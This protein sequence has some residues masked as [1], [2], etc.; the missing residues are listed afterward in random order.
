LDSQFQSSSSSSAGVSL[1]F[2]NFKP[3]SL[4]FS[5]LATSSN[6]GALGL[7][8]PDASKV[9][10]WGLL[11]P[12]ASKF[13]GRGLLESYLRIAVLWRKDLREQLLKLKV[14]ILIF[15]VP[16]AKLKL[17]LLL[18]FVCCFFKLQRFVL[19]IVYF[20][21]FYVY[22]CIGSILNAWNGIGLANVHSIVF[23]GWFTSLSSVTFEK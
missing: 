17:L 19:I 16:R 2:N 4:S 22:D 11:E 13:W 9:T 5:N 6:I 23:I 3:E 18:Y 12:E 10:G 7:L 20:R 1:Y 14:K 21:F 15:K 8:L